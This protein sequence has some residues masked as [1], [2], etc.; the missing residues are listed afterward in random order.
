MRRMSHDQTQGDGGD[1]AATNGAADALSERRLGEQEAEVWGDRLEA[2]LRKSRD[3]ARQQSDGAALIAHQREQRALEILARL[4]GQAFL[5]ERIA[6]ILAQVAPEAPEARFLIGRGE[7][8]LGFVRLTT[9]SGRELRWGRA[10]LESA[11][12]LGEDWWENLEDQFIDETEANPG[13]C[14]VIH[15]PT[16]EVAYLPGTTRDGS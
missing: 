6:R 9:D 8:G 3:L 11:H 4:T 7:T 14:V 5:L 2:R 13:D 1:D 10:H 12:E 15:L 16:R